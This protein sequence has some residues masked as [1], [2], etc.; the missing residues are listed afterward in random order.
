MVHAARVDVW[1]F[2]LVEAA[3]VEAVVLWWRSPGSGRGSPWASDG[4]WE[5]M[6]R[7]TN[8]GDYDALGADRQDA[9]APRAPALSRADVA[10]RDEIT[11]WLEWVAERDRRL[12]AIAVRQ[13]AATGWRSPGFLKIKQRYGADIGGALRK[14]YNRAIYTIAENLNCKGVALEGAEMRR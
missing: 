12:V 10:R 2:G 8:A 4:P 9:P 7:E 5:L 13:M 3:L 14:R 1:T 6:L 11:A